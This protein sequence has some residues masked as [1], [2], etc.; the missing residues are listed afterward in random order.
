M[1]DYRL[2]NIYIVGGLSGGVD[3]QIGA[4]IIPVA[5][6]ERI[7]QHNEAQQEAQQEPQ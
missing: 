2:Y 3:R 1:S 6:A 4:L 5:Q 7:P